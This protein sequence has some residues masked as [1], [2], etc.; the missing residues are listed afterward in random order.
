MNHFNRAELYYQLSNCYFLLGNE[1]KGK[2]NFEKARE[3]DPS[4]QVEMFKKYPILEN[5]AN[6]GMSKSE[7][8]KKQ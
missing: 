3:L 6:F 7:I 1:V 4:L 8:E 2:A 5:K